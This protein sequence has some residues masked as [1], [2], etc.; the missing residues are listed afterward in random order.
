VPNL[1]A[2][3]YF[4]AHVTIDP[5]PQ[6]GRSELERLAKEY[7]FKLAKLLMDKNVPSQL[8]TFLT[9]HSKSFIQICSDMQNLIKRL[10]NL[11]YKIRRYK[12]EDIVLD[13]RIED[14]FDL[15]P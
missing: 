2:D 11:G 12:I 3:L 7:N 1:T 5:V 15:L 10:T 14:V 9:G 6:E 13:S 4:E 8:D